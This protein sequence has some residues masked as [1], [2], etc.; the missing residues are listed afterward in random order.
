MA[1]KI[2]GISIEISGDT[3][4]LTQSLKG[5]NGQIAG[6]QKQL[7]DVERL[8]KLDPTN[9]EL[10]AQKQKLLSQA[11]NQT[12]EKLEQVKKMEA[13]ANEEFK[14]GK[15]GEEQY[16]A[17]KREVAATTSNL[18][19]LEKRASESNATLGKVAGELD[20]VSDKAEAA[21]SATKGISIAAGAAAIAI[22]SMAVKAGLA[23]DDL[24]TLSNQSGFSTETIQEWQYAADRIDVSVDSIIGAARKMK[25]NMDSTSTDVQAA[26]LRLGVSAKDVTTGQFRDAEAVFNDVTIA[27]SKIPNETERDILSM[28]IFGK[29]ADDLAGII[30]D[31]GAALRQMGEEAKNS[32]LILSQEALDGA[33][34]FND[35]I[36]TLKAK[37]Q[38]AFFEAGAALAENLLPAM[39]DLGEKIAAVI[40]WLA[41]LDGSTL[42]M[43]LK[44]ALV[45]AAISP[46]ASLV[47]NV[48]SATAGLI[49]IIP[50]ASGL[51]GSIN[52]E[53]ALTVAAM[54]ALALLT[55]KLMDAWD[56]MSSME[57]TVSVL[58]LVTA[59]ALTA[60]IAL[61][62]FQSAATMGAAAVGIAVGIGAV[63]ASIESAKKR[64]QSISSA[65]TIPAFANGGSLTYG[66][67][68]VGDA[69]AELLSVNNGRATVRP[70]SG[71]A[72][73][74]VN[75]RPV[76]GTQN[77]TIEFTGSLA[78]LGR[79]LQPV[80]RAEDNRV[81]PS[82]VR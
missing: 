10:L 15:I 35:G 16:D 58:G 19:S 5:V 62:A 2:R 38:A 60:A 27:L 66:S 40:E 49:G 44:I 8:L 47:S 1:A 9:T 34:A 28:Q 48:T 29:S 25:K 11:V 30:D 51:L 71:S 32:G 4:G 42:S 67:A 52:P 69:G 12:S 72:A 3:T 80:I 24:N 76:G 43:I 75:N 13:L 78:Q 50:K 54:G 61:G 36:D 81:G 56:D 45:V 14:A 18:E 31:G 37:A 33:N 77:V 23:A 21:A 7:R 70:L 17:I 53:I 55:A 65:S 79:V 39:D 6:T 41:Q 46:L 63:V 64:A 26:W 20:N 68:V 57:K 59:A 82:L 22:G 73:A 74:A